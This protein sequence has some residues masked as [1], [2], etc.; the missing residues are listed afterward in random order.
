[1]L[2]N[3]DNEIR[4]NN[5]MNIRFDYNIVKNIAVIVKIKN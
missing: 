5:V 4:K 2:I 1:M 3:E